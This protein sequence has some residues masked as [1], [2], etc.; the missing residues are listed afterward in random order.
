M[1]SINQ[2]ND[3]QDVQFWPPPHGAVRSK[4]AKAMC[5]GV[6]DRVWTC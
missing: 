3:V 5:G 6:V 1:S 4:W 2:A